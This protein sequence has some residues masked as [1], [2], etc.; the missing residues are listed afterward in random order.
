MRAKL[1]IGTINRNHAAGLKRTIESVV[2][3]KTSAV[4]YLVI[5]G[6]SSD[7]SVNI[8]RDHSDAIDFWV[9]EPDKG[10]SDAF[11]KVVLHATGDWIMLLNAGDTLLKGALDSI[12]AAC[13]EHCAAEIICGSTLAASESNRHQVLTP[14]I[15]LLPLEMSIAHPS[16][17]VKNSLYRRIGGYSND[18]RIAM[19]YRFFLNAKLNAAKFAVIESA[20]VEMEAGGISNQS[21]VKRNLDSWRARKQSGY[22]SIF[23]L[24]AFAR[25][26]SR[27]FIRSIAR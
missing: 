9:S 14:N 10:I 2:S 18:L 1:T 6:A 24:Y 20:L 25:R 11:N 21:I 7:D 13:N 8:I 12:L 23:N 15:S 4:E 17:I 27:D 19:D 22:N 26:V 5:D 3:Q 16:S